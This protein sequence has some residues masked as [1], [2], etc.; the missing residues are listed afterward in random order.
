[1]CL[2]NNLLQKESDYMSNK[3]IDLGRTSFSSSA[4]IK[5]AHTNFS[6]YETLVWCEL[7]DMEKLPNFVANCMENNIKAICGVAFFLRT[8]EN[9]LTR[10]IE[11]ICY[12]MD[13]EG[14][15]EL[16]FL[17]S[18]SDYGVIEYND[19]CQ[20]SKHLQV[21]ID[22]VFGEVEMLAI[23]NILETVFVPDFVLIDEN[24]DSFRSWE[25]CRKILEGK[26]ILICGGRFP[27]GKHFADETI[28]TENFAFL[29]DKAYE[30]V[31]ENPQKIA[32]RISGNYRFDVSLIE[33]IAEEK[34]CLPF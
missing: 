3:R 21:G 16:E 19:F 11:V 34:E 4:D 13:E 15:S 9:C 2:R 1:M 8:P 5:T 27:M 6:E 12:A 14:S 25:N 29:G 20:F 23:E 10:E 22:L 28:L 24:Q 26:N 33:K 17:Y 18:R 30:Y 31:I 32:D 7:G